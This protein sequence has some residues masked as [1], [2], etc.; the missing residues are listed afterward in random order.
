LEEVSVFVD[1]VSDIKYGWLAPRFNS[2]SVKLW[3]GHDFAKRMAV[4]TLVALLNRWVKLRAGVNCSDSRT[5]Y[6]GLPPQR[7]LN[8]VPAFPSR[9]GDARTRDA[10]DHCDSMQVRFDGKPSRVDYKMAGEKLVNVLAELLILS[11]RLSVSDRVLFGPHIPKL[12]LEGGNLRQILPNPRFPALLRF[13]YPGA[14]TSR[15]LGLH[16]HDVLVVLEVSQPVFRE[17]FESANGLIAEWLVHKVE[18]RRTTARSEEAQM[19]ASEDLVGL[20]DEVVKLRGVVPLLGE[21]T[22]E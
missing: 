20:F 11:I 12:V 1:F 17:V 9:D 13:C 3:S 15:R 22:S 14:K 2:F 19:T 10:F 21:V 18:K 16:P 8:F 4:Q 6:F 7:R 5:R